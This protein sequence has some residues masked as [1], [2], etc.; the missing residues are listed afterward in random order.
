MAVSQDQIKKLLGYGLANE[1]VASTVGCT[2]SYISQLLADQE[3]SEEVT[4][5]RIAHLAQHSENDDKLTRMETK[6]LDNLETAIDNKLI[7]KPHD[8]LKVFQVINAAKRRGAS[9]SSNNAP[10]GGIVQLTVPVHIVQQFVT[11]G[12][13]EVVEVAGQSLVTISPEKLLGMVK[14]RAGEANTAKY[15]RILD[16]M[17]SAV[18][19]D[20][21]GK[22]RI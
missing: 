3:F 10:P 1:V 6:L 22:E 20:R 2:P 5:L 8:V 19:I 4:K 15:Q 14:E 11:N 17:P 21:D 7:Y 12:Q 18:T 16:R 9:S 13:K